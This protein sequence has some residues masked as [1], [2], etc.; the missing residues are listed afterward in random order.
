MSHNLPLLPPRHSTARYTGWWRAW[1][2]GVLVA[3]IAVLVLAVVLGVVLARGSVTVT[4][5]GAVALVFLAGWTA[6]CLLPWA[7][8]LVLLTWWLAH[9]LPRVPT[10][11]HPWQARV[12]HLAQRAREAGLAVAHPVIQ[13]YVTA[14]VVREAAR[15]LRTLF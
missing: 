11:L 1:F 15:R 9:M 13:V 12:R 7:V 14:A 10:T 8:L 6:L 3:A 5:A 2:I 4:Q